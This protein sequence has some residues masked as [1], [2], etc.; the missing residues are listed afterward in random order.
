LSR[1]LV[2]SSTPSPF[3]EDHGGKQRLVKLLT[4]LSKRHGVT[5]LSLSWEGEDFS[6]SISDSL[7]HVSV[8]VEHQVISASRG[9][10]TLKKPNNDT[11][12]AYFKRYFKAYRAKL[13]ELAKVNDVIIVD[14][15]A[16]APF[17]NGLKNLDIPVFYSSQNC[18]TDLAKQ[19][20][21]AKSD[22]IRLINETEKNIID[23]STAIAYCSKD[24]Y[25][26]M[27]SYFIID[28]PSYY[29]P[30]GNDIVPGRVAGAGL[31][32]RNIVFIG[33]G[34]PPNAIAAERIL[35]L[36]RL[37]PE[38]NFIIA[39][40]C[41]G[42]IDHLPLPDN[43]TK[44]KSISNDEV[45]DMFSNAFAFIN[46]METGSGTHLKMMKAL[47]YGLP[48]IASSIGARGF[49]ESEKKN[50]MIIAEELS[51]MV[52]GIKSLSDDK[53]YISMSSNSLE[54]SK[55]YDWEKI[56]E[57]FMSAIEDTIAKKKVE[58]P[59][60]ENEASVIPTRK[61]KVLVYSIIRNESKYMNSYHNK[62]IEMVSSFPEYEFYLS[63]Y[64]NDSTDG[65][66][67]KIMA[68]DW[69]MFAGVSI[70]SENIATQDYGSVK[71]E[72]RVKNLSIARNKA[73]EAAGFL[74]FVDY[75]M[76]IESDMEF[77]MKA[78]EK[79][80]N[81]KNIVPDFDIVSGITIR[82]KRLYDQWATRKGPK[83]EENVYPIADDYKM[84][85]YDKY[86]STSN[87]ICLYRAEPFR[88]GVRYGYINTITGEFDCDTVVVC[89]NFQDRGYDGVYIIH[90][91]EIYHEHK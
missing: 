63:L 39:G 44:I 21:P 48:I 38:Y 87:G 67:Q 58:Q 60:M 30:N 6:A 25:D 64:E 80:L 55:E 91:A 49:S 81:F 20:F 15:Y 17:V 75:I 3:S 68:K 88:E 10:T 2:L 13:A 24:D 42:G 18:E 29:I 45:E 28:K 34:H 90:D 32:S 62:L 54:L 37:A 4:S 14:H 22:D 69:S 57:S 78:V 8:A 26:L 89:Q 12:I 84:K 52:G 16:T 66:K 85:S 27:K 72:T 61:E 7:K 70:I 36:A 47:S 33:S 76:M 41:V 56:G 71:D 51:D 5:L 82:N 74:D 50:C 40:A 65:T 43:V 46:P 53:K 73:I 23:D 19:M 86:Y 35:E 1:I 9:R 31:N 11:R 59:A 83:Y 79:I 77:D